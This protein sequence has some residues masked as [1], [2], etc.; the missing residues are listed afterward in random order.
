M[1]EYSIVSAL[2]SRVES[3]AARVG[4]SSVVK[5]LHVC[6][7]ELAGIDIPLLASAY[8]LFRDHT[9]CRDAELVIRAA[10]AVWKCPSC[11]LA[12]ARGER[13]Q[14]PACGRPARLCAGGEIILEKIEMEVPD[15]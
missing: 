3:E 2:V 6:I 13:L 10:E 7:G 9:V 5:R 11:D 4:P 14:C 8:D 12:I 1:H 15:V